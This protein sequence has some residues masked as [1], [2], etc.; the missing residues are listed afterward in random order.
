MQ[1]N[2]IVVAHPV[3]SRVRIDDA[4]CFGR[5]KAIRIEGTIEYFVS[6]FD[7]DKRRCEG[8]FTGDEIARA[9]VNA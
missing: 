8:W 7:E 6:W 4:A 3:G 2:V 9:G 5:V 1:S